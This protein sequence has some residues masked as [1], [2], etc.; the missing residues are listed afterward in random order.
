MKYQQ[1]F[2]NRLR[3][4]NK[5]IFNR[6]TLRFAGSSFSPISIIRHVGRRSGSH[7][8]TPVI[9]VKPFGDQFIF[10]L[11]Y[12]HNVDWYRNILAAGRGTVVC[13]GRE[14]QVEKP[15]PLDAQTGSVA[16]PFVL[17]LIVRSMGVQHFIQM[18]TAKVI[19]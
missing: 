18:K 14:Y 6:V 15:E 17:R 1:S 5:R 8:I 4:L 12:G 13:H 9:A 19:A 11:P 10:A 3:F 2:L 7:Y 16:L